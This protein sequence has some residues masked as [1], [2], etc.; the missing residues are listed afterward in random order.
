[1]RT[2]AQDKTSIGEL[3][4]LFCSMLSDD[5]TCDSDTKMRITG[6]NGIK[7][8]VM[9]MK[10]SQLYMGEV[11]MDNSRFITFEIDTSG[12]LEG[13]DEWTD[14]IVKRK[15]NCASSNSCEMGSV[16]KPSFTDIILAVFSAQ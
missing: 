9:K 3:G 5:S 11:N 16:D 15:F 1:M 7:P 2:L 8:Q 12:N 6:L 14:G 10:F 13:W 4:T